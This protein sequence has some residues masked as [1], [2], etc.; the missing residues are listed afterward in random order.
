MVLVGRS[1]ELAELTR[2]V[3]E[4]A[5]GAG[6]VVTVLGPAGSGRTTMLAEAAAVAEAA[7]LRVARAT[8]VPS[9]RVPP[10][11]QVL[12]ELEIADEV[13]E[14]L[15]GTASTADLERV[16]RMIA[17]TR[18]RLIL[19]DDLDRGDETTR[20]LAA[21]VASRGGGV[22]LFV[23]RAEPPVLGRAVPLEPWREADLAA[24]LPAADAELR[25]AVWVASRGLPGAA[26]ALAREVDSLSGAADPIAA[27]ALRAP[28]RAQFLESDLA[29]VRLLETAL[30]R[31]L[32]EPTRARVL[33]RLAS[34]LLGE[35][36]SAARRRRLAD[37]ALS[38]AR[39]AGDPGLLAD[40]LTARLNALWDPDG[41][42]D[43]LAAAAE[44]MDLARSGGDP[45][46]ERDALFWRFIALMELGRVRE[47]ESALAAFER[48]A[49][50][51]GDH[52]ALVM[53]RA[54]HAM[55]AV[56]RGRYD[57]A[58]EL[59]AAVATR[60]TQAGLA[61]TAAL[62]GTLNGMLLGDRGTRQDAARALPVLRETARQRPGHFYEATTAW[63][64]LRAG[65]PDRARAEA[66]RVLGTVL[67]G[68][69]PRWLGACAA[70]AVVA[71]A[72]G[73]TAAAAALYDKLAPYRSQYVVLGGANSAM[74]PVA[75]FLGELA[76]VLGRL[77]DAVTHFDR[78]LATD[79]AAGALPG[80]ARALAGLAETLSARGAGDD[81][82]RVQ[83]AL[84]RARS[85]AEQLGMTTVLD[86]L[87]SPAGVWILSRDGSDWL[88]EA[89]PE[90][91]RL[92]DFRGLA[93]LR[94]L[95]LAPGRDIRAVDLA[96]GGAGVGT[97]DLGPTLDAPARSAY[98]RRLTELDE[99]LRD[100]DRT[101]NQRLGIAL[102]AER[103]ALLDELRRATG[104]GGR[105]R[106]AAPE[107]ERARV[108][109]TRAIRIAIERIA[110]RAPTAGAH[111]SASVR[112]GLV[113]RY[114]P[115]PGGPDRWLA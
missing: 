102:E 64:H 100:A 49:R 98:R 43:R 93:Y 106:R 101:G 4:V 15:L 58:E 86:R 110:D 74:G 16:A 17:G 56:L 109:V 85:I 45:A 35:P 52:A 37:E 115:V 23:S 2:A 62:V 54:R 63:A 14:P 66:A 94:A 44:I 80:V 20:R 39:R 59:I 27:L 51:V 79:E 18:G 88:V 71:V 19:L 41:A 99:A 3:G 111:L 60:G 104:L 65:E 105:M 47:A 57:E 92:R 69:G 112:T 78:A 21:M 82:T 30:H 114:D 6:A 36:S 13:I 50:L 68:A 53:V 1:R 5:G 83:D 113:C 31:Q 12:R 34:E 26:V 61:D 48:E 7:G 81:V 28:S 91:A 97:A 70:L 46:R 40:V 33:A 42:A 107:A 89:G 76:R 9:G 11:V 10:W 24:L 22:G 55:L 73:D 103:E 8:V 87:P 108:N 75:Y 90:R 96:A 38:L 95:V 77:D 25:R 32:D 84:R 29:V 67:T 72:T